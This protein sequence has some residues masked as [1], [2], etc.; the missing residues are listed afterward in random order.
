MG[1]AA[2]G[3]ELAGVLVT[4]NLFLLKALEEGF[5]AETV[6]GLYCP[7]RRLLDSES[8][9][10]LDRIL[11]RPEVARRRSAEIRRIAGV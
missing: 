4:L 5:D 10:F 11:A 9:R 3:S 7:L 2:V 1:R 6:R 8:R